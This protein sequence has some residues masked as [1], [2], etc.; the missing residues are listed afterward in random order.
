MD[1]FM[2]YCGGITIKSTKNEIWLSSLLIEMRIN[3]TFNVT[4]WEKICID[5]SLLSHY[6]YL[7]NK[8]L[9]Y[10]LILFANEL[11]SLSDKLSFRANS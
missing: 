6:S 8:I 1:C 5:F 10:R 4:D 11:A 2:M 7:S 9:S 3:D